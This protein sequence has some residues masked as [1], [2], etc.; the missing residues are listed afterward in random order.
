MV[1]KGNFLVLSYSTVMKPIKTSGI[2]LVM[3]LTFGGLSVF[4]RPALAISPTQQKSAISTNRMNAESLFERGTKKIARG[5]YQGAIT[6]F[7][8]VIELN[9]NYIEAY[10]NRGMAHLGLGN[11]SQAIAEFD[12]ALQVAP[13][14][15]DALNR[16]G[17]VLAQQGNL[18]RAV[19]SFGRALS[20]DSNFMVRSLIMMRQFDSTLLWLKLMAIEG[21]SA[22]S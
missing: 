7:D 12:L 6:D 16:K 21:L 8:R 13:R 10:C 2:I 3:T 19:D 14:H 20:F 17:I 9:P 11:L 1:F 18:D 22:P 15:A 5:D 4:V